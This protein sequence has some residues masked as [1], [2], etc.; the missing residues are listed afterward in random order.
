MPPFERPYEEAIALFDDAP[1]SAEKDLAEKGLYLA[2][3]PS[4]RKGDL[5]DRPTLPSNLNECS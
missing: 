5:T 4:N 3:R 1:D 2:Q